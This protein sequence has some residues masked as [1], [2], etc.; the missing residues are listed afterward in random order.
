M[1]KKIRK[2][3]LVIA[4]FGLAIIYF[5]SYENEKGI[6]VITWDNLYNE[7][8]LNIYY[9]KLRN[10]IKINEKLSKL[11]EIY[12]INEICNKEKDEV[13]K[14]L[15]SVEILR[16]IVEVDDIKETKFLNGYDI[17]K[18]KNEN[19]KKLSDRDVAILER[20]LILILGFESR[21]GILK[22]ETPQ[23]KK[24]AEYYVVEYWSPKYN[25]WIMIDY[26]MKG[27]LAYEEE[28]IGALEAVEADINKFH[29]Y[30]SV[31]SKDYRKKINQYRASYTIP[32][33]NTVNGVFSN[34]F[35]TYIKNQK[36][37]DLLSEKEYLPPTIFTM[38]RTIYEKS[39]WGEKS[40]EDKRNYMILMKKTLDE[41]DKGLKGDELEREE[42]KFIVGVFKNVNMIKE[43]FYKIND[44][45][46]IKVDDKYV[47]VYLE[48]GKNKIQIS[49]DGKLVES[50]I[51][52]IREK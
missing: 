14:I 30:G 36:N 33:D 18:N 19:S 5:N 52:I 42:N 31:K 29:F 13:D 8:S 4:V 26:K 10:K 6:K 25:K 43:Y 3:C 37:I 12:K 27:Y 15:K 48:K 24:D 28:P 51:E 21:I 47:E 17:L 38:N 44:G 32:I 22:K 16:S 45:E 39:P 1:R 9:E 7:E 40:K 50:S 41:E 35:I 11:D 34:S 46:F 20:D 49:R 2:I 23:F